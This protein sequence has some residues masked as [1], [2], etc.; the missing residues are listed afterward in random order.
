MKKVFADLNLLFL[1][2]FTGKKKSAGM[3]ND[4]SVFDKFGL[5]RNDVLKFAIP[6]PQNAYAVKMGETIRSGRLFLTRTLEEMPYTLS[7]LDWNIYYGKIPESFQLYL[8]SLNVIQNLTH[9]YEADGN[10]ENLVL[11][12]KLLNSWLSFESDTSLSKKN[13]YVWGDHSSANRAE[14][15]IYYTIVASDAGIIEQ[16]RKIFLKSLIKRHGEFLSKDKNYT[17][18]HN[19]GIFQ[20]RALLY[21]AYFLNDENTSEYIK[22][23]QS[24]LTAQWKYAL[25]DEMVSVENSS[26]YHLLARNLIQNI[27][28]F[29][30]RQGNDFAKSMQET[31]EK[32]DDFSAFMVR[33]DGKLSAFG[34]S[35][36][37]PM[38]Y[39]TAKPG[40]Y[41]EYS[42]SLGEIGSPPSMTSMLYPRSGYY[43]GREFWTT[44]E[45]H[46]FSDS[47]WVMFKS[48][49]V[50][51]THKH[52]DD[53]S[54][55][56]YSKG[57]E[58]F[59]DAG[60]YGYVKEPIYQYQISSKSHNTVIVDNN[61]YTIPKEEIGNSGIIKSSLCHARGYDYIIGHNFLYPGV[62]LIRHFIYFSQ[63]LFIYDDI[64]S[65]DTHTY[66]QLFHHSEFTKLLNHTNNSVLLQILDT[67]FC[68]RLSQLGTSC[69]DT[70]LHLYNGADPNSE[71]G[72]ISRK[73][74]ETINIGTLKFDQTGN[75][76]SFATLIQIEDD[77]GIPQN[78]KSFQYDSQS[79]SIHYIL[80]NGQSETIKLLSFETAVN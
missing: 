24:R 26:N 70:T 20:D 67:S 3:I 79:N 38:P 42:A 29:L 16:K 49:Y 60:L 51:K 64:I 63:A 44:P 28:L 22:I 32:M 40:S 68:V 13:K 77:K 11:A 56:L 46:S 61:T 36:E 69:S 15:L 34:D 1:K 37:Q 72:K 48:G 9:A 8:N 53:N 12:E 47:T 19:H 57:H 45:N 75:N 39:T 6:S 62:K 55:L 5:N 25:T 17:F 73:Y 30:L 21:I 2:L 4:L 74:G 66:S 65:A 23:A 18:R 7:S 54:F 59:S 10:M 43:F 35:P 58:I 52:A 76:T 78:F 31:L 41:L 50:S 71:Y 33:P 14:I 80:K 27:N